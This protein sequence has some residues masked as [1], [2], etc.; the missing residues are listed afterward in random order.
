MATPKREGIGR[1]LVQNVV[2]LINPESIINAWE[3]ANKDDR[4][5]HFLQSIRLP[6]TMNPLG[7]IEAQL[8]AIEEL[9]NGAPAHLASNGSMATWRR[10]LMSMR[11][12]LPL[13]KTSKGGN[14][15]QRIKDLDQRVGTL[16][17]EIYQALVEGA[18]NQ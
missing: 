17:A 13:V 8:D 16:Q 18:D 14:R 10:S 4:V 15:R 5:I 2:K 3:F 1:A 9:L 11:A 6:K 7:R 12:A